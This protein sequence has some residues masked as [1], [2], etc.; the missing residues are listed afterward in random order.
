MDEA[1]YLFGAYRF[2]PGK[3]VFRGDTQI[4]LPPKEMALL[5]LLVSLEGR[6]ASHELIETTL[7]PRQVVSYASLARCVHSLRKSLENEDEKYIQTVPKRGYRLAVPLRRESLVSS[8]SARAAA[9]QT[10]PLANAHFLQ[11][12]REANNPDSDS[13]E[14]AIH[15]FQEAL[16]LNPGFASAHAAIADIRFW[17]VARGYVMPTEGLKR[18][19]SGCQRAL[20]YDP[21]LVAASATQ[22]LIVAILDRA[23]DKAL[24]LLDEALTHEPDYA[25]GYT[26]R[27]LL[28]RM[29][30]RGVRRGLWGNGS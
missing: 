15:W 16:K 13:A 9:I 1:C 30:G 23:P 6:I 22:A 2:E 27:Y 5:R 18:A 20:R 10:T 11:G 17:Q 26:Y 28:L 14:R 29:L 25:R 7:W 3:G 21:S 8:P 12:L 4:A 24:A 19:R